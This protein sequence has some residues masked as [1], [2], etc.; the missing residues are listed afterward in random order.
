SARFAKAAGIGAGG[1]PVAASTATPAVE[2]QGVTVAASSAFARAARGE[3][4]GAP[5]AISSGELGGGGDDGDVR[6]RAIARRR[7]G[8]LSPLAGLGSI[9]GFAADPAGSAIAATS[10]SIGAA[11][12]RSA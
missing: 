9:R 8:A 6:S 3:R 4:A 10:S 7:A 12:T 5:R 1:A 2:F 11:F